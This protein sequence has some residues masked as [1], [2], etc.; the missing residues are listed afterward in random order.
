MTTVDPKTGEL[1]EQIRPFAEL[2]TILDRGAAHAEASRALHD[3]V[4]AV[5]DTGKKGSM[6]VA[7]V[8][9]P[10][11]G[12]HDQLVVAAQVTAKPP[13]SEPAAAIFYA[14]DD[15]NLTRHDP[16]QLEIDGVRVVEPKP[17]R[18]V[19]A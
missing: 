3:L 18:T 10:L 1:D 8:L 12:S 7:L 6:S 14:D 5:R 16:R 19:N 17:A 11:K 4:A 15:G 2:L 13:K 9:S